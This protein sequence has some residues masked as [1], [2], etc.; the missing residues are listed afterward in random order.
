MCWVIDPQNQGLK[1]VLSWPPKVSAAP[2]RMPLAA[3]QPSKQLLG[4]PV[5]AKDSWLN[6][7]KIWKNDR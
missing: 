6:M 4:L 1:V 3:L 7:G 5:M 2:A